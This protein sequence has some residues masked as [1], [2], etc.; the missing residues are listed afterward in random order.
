M[1]RIDLID[2]Q[3]EY[4]SHLYKFVLWPRQWQ[5]FNDQRNFHWTQT[6]LRV[7][8]R[9]NIPDN[10]GIYSLL[11]QPNIARHPGCSYLMYVGKAVSLRRRFNDY[12]TSER[13]ETGR[14]MI[15]RMLNKYS[16]YLVFCYILIREADLIATEIEIVDAFMPPTNK[17]F[18]ADINPVRGAF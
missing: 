6:P 3:D 12:L 16:D 2:F 8:E 9:T 5:S 15:Y 13:R 7:E 11:I 10:S 4:A 1:P 17:Q 14:P 18:S